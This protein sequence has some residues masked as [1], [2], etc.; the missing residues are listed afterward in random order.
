MTRTLELSIGLAAAVV[1][2][3]WAWQQMRKGKD[4]TFVGPAWSDVEVR[5]SLVAGAGNG[6]FAKRDFA[7]GDVICDYR[8]KVLS[9]AQVLRLPPEARDYLMGGFGLNVHIDA[10]EAYAVP[11]RYVNDNFD[12]A[13]LNAHFRKLPKLRKAQVVALRPILA[14]DE[15]YAAYGAAYWR[16]RES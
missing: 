7:R 6:L 2:A 4:E 1:M 11:G 12:T 16:A 13:R 14:G 3:A 8:G 10:S 5:R 15:I 9:L